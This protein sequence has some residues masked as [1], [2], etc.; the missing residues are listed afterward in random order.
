MKNELK[1][2]GDAN[3]W[4]TVPLEVKDCTHKKEVIKLSNCYT[5]YICHICNFRY[6]VDSGD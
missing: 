3:G 5:A 6:A 4:S 1:N 2:L